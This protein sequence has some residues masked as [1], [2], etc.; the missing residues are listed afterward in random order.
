MCRTKLQLHKRW[1]GLKNQSCQHKCE[2]GM[3][4]LIPCTASRRLTSE[5]SASAMRAM[6]AGVLPCLVQVAFWTRKRQF[7][8][9]LVASNIKNSAP[10]NW[11]PWRL[12]STFD[13]NPENAAQKARI[14]I[15]R[16][17]ALPISSENVRATSDQN[18]YNLGL[19]GSKNSHS[20]VI[21]WNR[22][23]WC[24]YLRLSQVPGL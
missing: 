17:R 22:L 3:I 24:Q 7:P 19:Q 9:P 5:G 23:S 18:Q 21:F 2:I 11:H 20:S 6:A 4:F 13:W 15:P 12:L 16:S 14:H 10:R 8:V 1:H